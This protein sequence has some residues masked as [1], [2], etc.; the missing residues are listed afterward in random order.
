M[1]EG[2]P[3]AALA[4]HKYKIG[5]RQLLFLLDQAMGYSELPRLLS[6]GPISKVRVKKSGRSA[7]KLHVLDASYEASTVQ[8]SDSFYPYD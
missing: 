1:C 8:L 4:L 3:L 5:R 6:H 7:T 2:D